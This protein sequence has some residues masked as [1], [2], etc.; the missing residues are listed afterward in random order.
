MSEEEQNEEDGLEQNEEDGLD[1]TVIIGV[2][3]LAVLVGV[4]ALVLLSTMGMF[5]VSSSVEDFDYPN[6]TSADG[7]NNSSKALTNH[8]NTLRD[9]SYTITASSNNSN[10]STSI[11]YRYNNETRT[12]RT[13]RDVSGEEGTELYENYTTRQRY[14]T[15]N[16]GTQE[17]NFSRSF[18]QQQPF[19]ADVQVGEFVLATNM[20]AQRVEEGP[21]GNDVVVYEIDNV[22]EQFQGRF[23]ITGEVH[24]SDAGYFTYADVTVE[25]LDNE[26]VTSTNNQVL[27]IT[28]IGSTTVEEPDWLDEAQNQT[29]E[30]Q[31]PQP[32]T[33]PGGNTN[34][35]DTSD[36]TSG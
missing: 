6:G 15:T 27:E 34:E 1:D 14:V 17:Q 21:N 36:N 31:P 4:G 16:L 22:T 32:Q 26:T 29:E 5:G 19:T 9:S 12:S 18:I 23:N 33:R 30:A 13:E 10:T 8:A 3:I 24:L 35:T 2:G 28:E 20:T 25:T 7:V 11:T